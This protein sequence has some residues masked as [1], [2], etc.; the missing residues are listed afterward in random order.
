MNRYERLIRLEGLA[1]QAIQKRLDEDQDKRLNGADHR[2]LGWDEHQ[3][4]H[5]RYVTLRRARRQA[6]PNQQTIFR[7][8]VRRAWMEL[9]WMEQTVLM[10]SYSKKEIKAILQKTVKNING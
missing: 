6:N 4:L 7:G 9:S 8:E 2:S 3:S 5:K 1:S 10:Q